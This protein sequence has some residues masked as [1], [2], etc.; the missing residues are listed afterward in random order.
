MA[1][2]RGPDPYIV[3]PS[4]QPFSS[5]PADFSYDPDWAYTDAY[6]GRRGYNANPRIDPSPSASTSYQRQD[7]KTNNTFL[8]VLKERV[9]AILD[10]QQSS[11][12]RHSSTGNVSEPL[13][14]QFHEAPTS[15]HQH[16]SLRNQSRELQMFPLQTGADPVV[17][18]RG[19]HE[20]RPAVWQDFYSIDWTPKDVFFKF[21]QQVEGY[22]LGANFEFDGF[23]VDGF[24][25][26][27]VFKPAKGDRK[28]KL[29]CE[30]KHGD[31]RLLTKKI[32]IGPL[33]NIQ[34]GIG[35]D[36]INHTTGWK[37]KVTTSLGGDGVSQIRHKTLLPI[38]PGID[39][40]VG[41]NAEY[42]LPDLHGA[43][44]T[45]DPMV[46]L[47]LGHLYASVERVEAIYT[48]TT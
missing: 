39:F 48:H 2:R 26:K 17:L 37:W 6:R 10:A 15:S 44:G 25:T 7:S 43:L 21:R 36:W 5:V 30:P 27:F 20:P 14:P 35:H 29:I 41:W 8:N 1:G 13:S 19:T 31:L 11:S 45:G 24:N 32:P 38:C 28:W 4:S 9:Q 18:E 46:G 16:A 22:Q 40:R 3:S 12:P 42:V 23:K 33:L 47:N 34:V